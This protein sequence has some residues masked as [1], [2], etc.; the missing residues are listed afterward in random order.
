ML[1]LQVTREKYKQHVKFVPQMLNSTL[2]YFFFMYKI[3][4][5]LSGTRE[6]AFLLF[7][8]CACQ[9]LFV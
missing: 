7:L 4:A 6:N 3:V 8:F 1:I 5:G 9:M 2:S